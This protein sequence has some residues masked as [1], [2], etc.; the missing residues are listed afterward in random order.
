[1][2]NTK[3]TDPEVLEWRFTVRVGSFSIRQ[4]SSGQGLHDSGE[5]IQREVTF[6]EP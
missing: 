5:G 2:T 1:M 4:N 6:L 3:M